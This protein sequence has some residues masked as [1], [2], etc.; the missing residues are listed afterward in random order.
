MS[1]SLIRVRYEPTN[2]TIE[3]QTIRALSTW[4]DSALLEHSRRWKRRMKQT[5]AVAPGNPFAQMLDTDDPIC[6]ETAEAKRL[7]C[8]FRWMQ[9]NAPM[10]ED[11]EAD[12]QSAGTTLTALSETLEDMTNDKK[13]INIVFG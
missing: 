13:P 12:T 11:L 10:P 6:L 2:C 5:P 9:H 1:L 7:I 8:F 4:M 3:A